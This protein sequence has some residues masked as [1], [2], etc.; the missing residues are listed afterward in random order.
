MATHAHS[1]TERARPLLRAA[2]RPCRVLKTEDV[3]ALVAELPIPLAGQTPPPAP[4][5]SLT[6]AFSRRAAIFG[7]VVAPMALAS[8]AARAVG[9]RL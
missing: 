4:L 3:L 7:A 2:C 5:P 1:T 6:T 9:V 8:P